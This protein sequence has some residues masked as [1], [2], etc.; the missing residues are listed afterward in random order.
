MNE[1]RDFRDRLRI[2]KHRLD[3]ELEVQSELQE[4]IA[5][6]LAEKNAQ[7]LELKDD[8]GKTEARLIEDF[9][10]GSTKDLAEAKAKRHPDRTKAWER[11]QQAVRAFEEWSH[12]LDA[13][14]ARGRDLHTLGK[15]FG[16]SYFS[17]TSISGDR[18]RNRGRDRYD[19]MRG[20][21]AAKRSRVEID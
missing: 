4:Q 14:K 18:D 16:D 2:N 15:L 1:L 6:I 8:L 13:W 7:M 20:A 5:R 21:V 19:E 10:E 3:D 12:L 17:L 11:Y 9:R